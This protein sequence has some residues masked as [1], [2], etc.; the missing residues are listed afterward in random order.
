MNDISQRVTLST[1]NATLQ[2]APEL[3]G[4]IVQYRAALNGRQRDILRPGGSA[5][6]VL[7][8]AC[9]PLV[10]YSNR[11]RD[12]RFVWRG[13][14]VSL[15]LNHLPEKHSIH[16]HGWQ[17]P[18]QLSSRTQGKEEGKEEE[19]SEDS[20]TL[21]Y[22]HPAGGW[23]FAYYV[24]QQFRLSDEGLFIALTLTNESAQEM[25]AG[26]GFHPYFSRTGQCRLRVPATQMWA[27]DDEVMPTGIVAAPEALSQPGG[28]A[29]ADIDLD[30]ALI[31]VADPARS[32]LRSELRGEIDWPEWQ[33]KAT[34]SASDNCAFV[35]LYSPPGQDFFCLEP[36]THCTDAIN[37]QAK[38]I[39]GTGL[40]VLPPGGQ[41]HA[42]MQIELG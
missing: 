28:M 26:L 21:V 5:A 27:V 34:I 14:A 29:V 22:R 20:L 4:A 1:A 31:N 6:S 19:K 10:P 3:G 16:G 41:M 9:F 15:A 23:P 36:V 12:G 30:N 11:I 25:P 8:A 35:V 38:G 40:Q 37:M 18:W 17:N 39:A 2:L 7:E 32:Q 13:Q 42:W 24:E 33:G